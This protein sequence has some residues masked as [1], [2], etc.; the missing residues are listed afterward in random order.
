MKNLILKSTMFLGA[1]V[2]MG[3][4]AQ[5]QSLKVSVPFAFEANGKSLPAGEYTIHEVTANGGGIYS[6]RNMDTRDGVLLSGTH[7]IAYNDAQTKLVFQ[8]GADGYYLTEVWDGSMAR[9]VRAPRGRNSIL[10]STK[11]SIAARK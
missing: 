10:A 3:F 2:A 6:M 11:V 4:A 7:P 5:A 9:A 8:Q 1:A